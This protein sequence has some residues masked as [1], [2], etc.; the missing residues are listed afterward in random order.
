MDFAFAAAGLFA[1]RF[2]AEPVPPGLAFG[3]DDGEAAFGAVLTAALAGSG[4]A[5]VPISVGL[6]VGVGVRGESEI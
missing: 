5:S 3:V 6:W 2:A 4:G 1:L